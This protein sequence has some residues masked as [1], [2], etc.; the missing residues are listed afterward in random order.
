M[1][2]KMKNVSIAC[3]CLALSTLGGQAFAQSCSS[4][5]NL[6]TTNSFSGDTCAGT[7]E[8]GTYCGVASS[9]QKEQVYSVTL[10]AG[11]TATSIDLTN[12][13][14][15][16]FTPGLVLFQGTCVNGDNCA[17]NSTGTAG[18][19]TSLSLS[20][21]TAGNY[22]LAVTSDP[23][24]ASSDCGTY[25]LAYTGTLPVKLQSFNIN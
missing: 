11:Y 10:G 3:L 2:K 21:V 19:N 9:A 5:T 22:F 1:E 7:N 15:A 23:N 14:G 17:A 20:G 25:G 16:S 12:T 18:G 8:I 24:A 13:G 6:N 4:P